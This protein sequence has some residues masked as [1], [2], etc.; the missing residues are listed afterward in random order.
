[1]SQSY[2]YTGYTNNVDVNGHLYQ[3]YY[4]NVY[5]G[6]GNYTG[7]YRTPSYTPIP[8]CKYTGSNCTIGSTPY[9]YGK[10]SGAAKGDSI[11]YS[12]QLPGDSSKVW[13]AG[14]YSYTT[15]G[16]GSNQS[17]PV[18]ASL[19]PSQTASPY[20]SADTYLDT[21]IATISY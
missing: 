17:I 10:M 7:T 4:Y 2:V 15:T 12:I 1:V 9:A 6:Q 14:N 13:N 11:A 20:P 16:T 5:D 18:V 21:V 3:T 8:G 19:V